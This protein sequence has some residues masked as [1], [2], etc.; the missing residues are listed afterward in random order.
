V[1]LGRYSVQSNKGGTQKVAA[2]LLSLF[3][4]KEMKKFK[5]NI[6]FLGDGFVGKTAILQRLLTGTFSNT[7]TP[8][9][10][11]TLEMRT[12]RRPSD[13]SPMDLQIFDTSGS[14]SFPAMT[15]V[16]I[17]QSDA[18]VIVYAVDS[19]KS[20]ECAQRLAHE[21][22]EISHL[23]RVP[24]LI[25]GNKADLN[26]GRKVSFERGLQLAVK[27]KAPFMEV[28]AKIGCKMDD[29]FYTLLKRY[30]AVELLKSD[31]FPSC[32]LRHRRHNLFCRKQR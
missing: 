11:E 2:Y 22:E 19:E 10:G 4:S 32:I 15:R 9:V 8:T 25:V 23:K 31:E 17:G 18:F 5:L 13:D 28:S 1:F 16:L 24:L 12:K 30:D 3:E 20:F 7:Y 14:L 27:C 26:E 6:S 21:V 29:I